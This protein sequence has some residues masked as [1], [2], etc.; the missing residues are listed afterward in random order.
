MTRW[1]PAASSW[2]AA[3]IAASAAW[4]LLLLAAPFAAS[5]PH[6]SP[7]ASVLIVGVYGIGSLV[8][9]QLSERSYHLWS[10]QMPVCA[11]CAGIYAGA[12]VAAIFAALFRSADAVRHSTAARH[13][14]GVRHSAAKAVRHSAAKAVRHSTAERHS[15]G[16]AAA[17]TFAAS[18]R[19]AEAVRHRRAIVA[20]GF[21][22]A[23]VALALAAMPTL[24]TLFYE[25]TTGD[26]PSHAI[27]AAVGVP[28]GVAVAWLVV[29][30][31]D[32]QVN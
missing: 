26:M 24:I 30:A 31:A 27:R 19:T 2:R 8:C 5:R 1:R 3:F 22:P 17:A 28:I 32:N 15:A 20:Q 4:A 29:A 13:S 16:A 11:R 18:F 10:A 23:R 21:S 6:S 12:A 14:T 7:L 9:H 25:W